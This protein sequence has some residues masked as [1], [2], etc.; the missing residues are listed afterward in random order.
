MAMTQRSLSCLS[1]EGFHRI[2]WTEWGRADSPVLV[3]AHGMT[4]N[5]RDFDVLAAALEDRWRIACPDVVGRGKS[6]WLVDFSGY[7]FPQYLSDMAALLARLDVDEVDWVGT[8]MGGLI[9]MMLAAQPN[10]PIRRLVIN[11]IGPFIPKE[12]FARLRQYVGTDPRFSDRNAVE[13]YLRQVH[14]P[15]GDLEGE[16]WRHLAE[17]G[18]RPLDAGGFGL[19]YDPAIARAAFATEEPEDADMWA[20]WDRVQCPVLVLRGEDSDLLLPETVDAMKQRGPGCESVEIG[21]CGHAPALMADDQIST[22][23]KWL[24]R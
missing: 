15:F 5:G 6:D 18:A 22:V 16:Q 13:A 19:A 20:I 1:P 12:F 9:G 4:R 23:R 3:C 11:D 8:S 21:G 2:A 7:G 10:T 14:A 24:D 17:H